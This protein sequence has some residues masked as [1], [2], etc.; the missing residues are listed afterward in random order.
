VT[1]QPVGVTL[2]VNGRRE[3]GHAEPRVTLAEFLREELGLTGTHVGC[4]QGVCGACTVVVDGVAVRSC[5]MFAVQ[6]EGCDVE[7]VEGLGEDGLHPLQQAFWD[8]QALQCG[9]CTPGFLMTARVALEERSDWDRE[10]LR[11]RLGGNLCRCT[12]YQ[13]IV[14]AV[15]AAQETMRR[16]PEEDEQ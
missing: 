1:G 10:D 5:L 9:F 11:E 4:E 7:T 15:L 12:G 6:A 2:R 13:T 16:P 3:V 14:D 8:A